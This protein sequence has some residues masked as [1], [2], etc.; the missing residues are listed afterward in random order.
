MKCN[1]CGFEATSLQALRAHLRR[2]RERPRME[3]R[4]IRI[5]DEDWSFLKGFCRRH[6]LTTCHAIRVWI[7]LL[8]MVDEG[9]KATLTFEDGKMGLGSAF[10]SNPIIL[11]LSL[12]E[13]WLGRPRSA[14]KVPVPKFEERV[15]HCPACGD[16]KVRVFRPLRELV[17]G[18]CKRCGARWLVHE[19]V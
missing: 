6:G 7:K 8:R 11:N 13:T 9:R 14:W 4:S 17:E 10:G 18:E 2:C 12:H 15:P 3:V 19:M 16:V 1:Y 5:S